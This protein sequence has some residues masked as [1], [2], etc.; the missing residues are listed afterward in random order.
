MIGRGL[1]A[2]RL[3]GCIRDQRVVVEFLGGIGRLE[4]CGFGSVLG[5]CRVLVFRVLVIPSF[6]FVR[7]DAP[8]FRIVVV[9]MPNMENL[10]ER[11]GVVPLGFE[12]LRQADRFGEPF[13]EVGLQIIDPEGLRP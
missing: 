2:D 1:L 9:S 13:A 10:S 8:G 11:L 7:F 5:V 6:G 4:G 3:D 12:M